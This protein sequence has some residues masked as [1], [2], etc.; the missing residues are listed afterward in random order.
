MSFMNGNN[1]LFQ[2]KIKKN[3]FNIFKKS[4][5]KEIL[6]IAFKCGEAWKM[7]IKRKTWKTN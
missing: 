6:L 2:R 3:W 1:I 5:I 7:K 4:M